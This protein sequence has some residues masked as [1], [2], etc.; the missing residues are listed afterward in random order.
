MSHG[1]LMVRWGPG[2]DPPSGQRP[3]AM[4]S[5][6]SD[7]R[8]RPSVE[9]TTRPGHPASGLLVPG[10]CILV[11][12]SDDP[13]DQHGR[14]LL[15][16]VSSCRWIVLIADGDMYDELFSDYSSWRSI[17]PPAG[18][19]PPGVVEVVEFESVLTGDDH[20]T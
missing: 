20:F 1:A 2:V 8:G 5:S 3:L 19:F 12:Y 13:G 10:V 15:C 11:L 6:Q 14:Y 7:S 18:R 4:R 16:R 9:A 17:S